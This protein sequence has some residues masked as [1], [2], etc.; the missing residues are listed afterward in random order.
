MTADFVEALEHRLAERPGGSGFRRGGSLLGRGRRARG[1]GA[2]LAGRGPARPSGGACPSGAAIARARTDG[3]S[4]GTHDAG[5]AAP[6]EEPAKSVGQSSGA[7]APS[8]YSTSGGTTKNSTSGC[9]S[10]SSAETRVATSA[11]R[12]GSPATCTSS[13]KAACSPRSNGRTWSD[14]AL[15]TLKR[16]AVV[17]DGRANWPSVAGEP[18]VSN[19][20]I[21]VQWCHGAPGV[22]TALSAAA[23][24]RR[25]LERATA[26]SRSAGVG[27]GPDPRRSRPVP[28]NC[29][30]CIRAARAVAANR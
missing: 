14:R 22:L 30:E 29:G 3:R 17:E 23:P 21:R 4:S 12:T 1:G 9:G 16:F 5:R 28:W 26:R 24:G 20:R 13:C 25:R 18:L 15:A 10:R 2:L 6:R 27:S 11:P 19:D 8:V 7:R